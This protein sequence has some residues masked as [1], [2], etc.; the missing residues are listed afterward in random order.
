MD[1]EVIWRITVFLQQ[2]RTD[3]V[4]LDRAVACH[5]PPASACCCCLSRGPSCM[6]LVSRNCMAI[7][8]NTP[9]ALLPWPC[10]PTCG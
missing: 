4:F 7:E 6:P 1:E 8:H 2:I 9:V 3:Q 5:C 10:E